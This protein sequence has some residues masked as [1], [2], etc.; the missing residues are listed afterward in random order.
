MS[1]LVEPDVQ[2]VIRPAA[3]LVGAATEAFRV[4]LSN[5][6]DSGA[7][8]FTVDL[9]NVQKIDAIGLGML[10]AV[11]N[12]LSESGGRVMISNASPAITRMLRVMRL[13]RILVI[14]DQGGS[15]N[16]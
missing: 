3:D 15:S 12:K 6:L 9:C 2:H 7:K 16:G 14:D 8:Q 13:D 5:Q 11:A 4:E 10:V 1:K